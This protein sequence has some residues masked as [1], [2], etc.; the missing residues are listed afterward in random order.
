MNNPQPNGWHRANNK[1]IIE[2]KL[3]ILLADRRLDGRSGR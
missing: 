2:Q 1:K 3:V